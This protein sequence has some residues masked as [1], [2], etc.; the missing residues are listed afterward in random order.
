MKAENIYTSPIEK[1][2]KAGVYGTMA[3]VGVFLTAFVL[4][5]AACLGGAVYN[6]L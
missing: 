5:S 1:T 6:L 3:F 2:Y 4:W